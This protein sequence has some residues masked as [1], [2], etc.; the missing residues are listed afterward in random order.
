MRDSCKAIAINRIAILHD[1]R[2]LYEA[3]RKVAFNSLLQL[4]LARYALRCRH[5]C[6]NLANIRHQSFG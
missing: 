6:L 4:F 3:S 2:C 5:Q 1:D